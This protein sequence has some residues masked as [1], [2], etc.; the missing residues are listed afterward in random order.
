MKRP[1]R[2]AIRAASSAR[3]PPS[4]AKT[5]SGAS[6]RMR[7]RYARCNAEQATTTPSGEVPASVS[8]TVRS[9][10]ARSSSVSG[11]PEAILATFAAGCSASP[12]MNGTP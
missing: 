2:A 11:V 6:A 8:P 10:G 5:A 9:Q 3:S 7:S 4:S 12:S 1:G